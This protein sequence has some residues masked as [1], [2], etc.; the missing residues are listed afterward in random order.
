M[1]GKKCHLEEMGTIQF[2]QADLRVLLPQRKVLLLEKEVYLTATEFDLL[3]YLAK[4]PGWVFTKE[5]IY[6][7]VWGD[8]PVSV[9]AKVECMIYSIRKKLR[10]YTD[11]QYI[12]TV[13]GV[14]YKFD[15]GT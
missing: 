7:A 2:I 12:H 14:G 13:W 15:P 6:E 11:R 8:I 5:Q 1:P 3:C 4:H 10:K 9:D